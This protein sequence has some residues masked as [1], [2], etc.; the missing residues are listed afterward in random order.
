VHLNI[1]FNAVIMK[2]SL[3]ID[4][5]LIWAT[6]VCKQIYQNIRFKQNLALLWSGFMTFDCLF[7]HLHF[8]RTLRGDWEPTVDFLA[9]LK[10][11][12]Q[13]E[14]NFLTQIEQEIPDPH[15]HLNPPA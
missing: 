3:S 12:S 6:F 15:P 4:R 8:R 1:K 14:Q 13:K 9:K 11:Q 2:K 10:T 5:C 7:V